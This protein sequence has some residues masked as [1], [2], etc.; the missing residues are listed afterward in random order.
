MR[1]VVVHLTKTWYPVQSEKEE[2]KR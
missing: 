1:K 2:N